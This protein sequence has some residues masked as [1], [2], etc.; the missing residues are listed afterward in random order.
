MRRPA[1]PRLALIMSPLVLTVLALA[2]HHAEAKE[3]TIFNQSTQTVYIAT[4]TYQKSN[5][6]TSH[7]NSWVTAGWWSVA[8]G[9][10][11][12]VYSGEGNTAFVRMT[13]GSWTGNYIGWN[14]SRY[15]NYANSAAFR[16][17]ENESGTF[18]AYVVSPGQKRWVY[19]GSSLTTGGWNLVDGFYELSSSG[20]Y[21]IG[22]PKTIYSK[23][24]PFDYSA[25][26]NSSK[27]IDEKF[28]P[29]RG[30]KLV[31]YTVAVSSS[32]GGSAAWSLYSSYMSVYGYIL[33]S[34]KFYDQWSARYQGTLTMYY[35]Y[36]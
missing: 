26:W 15:K 35:T 32:R 5:Q 6:T 8:P 21:W 22:G 30:S 2:S 18:P 19:N 13:Y 34:G 14:A 24:I 36:P 1:S 11:I 31:H 33:G 23:N 4:S 10:V 17:E 9:S 20:S 16:L 12:K 25:S 7:Y 29:P 3:L 28:Y 27:T